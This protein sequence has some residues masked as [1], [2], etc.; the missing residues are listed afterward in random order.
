MN[1]Q[2]VMELMQRQLDDDL[3]EN[4]KEVLMSHT[5]QCPDCAAMF[6]RL[7]LLSAE[8]T[9]LPK[10]IPSYSL[11][12]AIMPQLERI[13]L[14][15]Q[16]EANIEPNSAAQSTESMPRRA[17][18]DRRWPSMRIMSG[19][20]AAGI[21][22]G[23]FL[24][25]Y[26]P[27]SAPDLSLTSKF[28]ANESSNAAADMAGEA[29]QER[30]LKAITPDKAA[31]PDVST[32]AIKKQDILEENSIN[33]YQNES[34]GNRSTPAEDS[35]SDA[36]SSDGGSSDAGS[37]NTGSS[38]SIADKPEDNTNGGV[39]GGE[40]NSSEGS[41]GEHEKPSFGIAATDSAVDSPDG[42]YSGEAVGFSIKLFDKSDQS[43][44]YETPRKNGKLANLSWSEDSLKLTY[45]VQVENGA[46]E[47]YVIDVASLTEQKAAH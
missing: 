14:F 5:R 21:V 33:Q 29:T 9:S 2:E 1:C 8:L 12:D 41:V 27:G 13:E 23:L 17:K 31:A 28:A 42:K 36:G 24:V 35:D 15:G 37:S 47:K 20:I 45:E 4:E 11:V 18:R 25:T 40:S 30:S 32:E 3:D 10:V 34:T 43:L 22:A 46:I 26:K 16:A 19:V 39:G 44:L 38:P 6:E 7:Q